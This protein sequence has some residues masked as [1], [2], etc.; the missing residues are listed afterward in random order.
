MASKSEEEISCPKCGH[1][2]SPRVDQPKRCPR[3]GKWLVSSEKKEDQKESEGSEIKRVEKRDGRVVEFDQSKITEAIWSAAQSIGGR[4]KRLAERLSDKVVKYI[5]ENIDK[6]VPHVEEIQDA[7]E[8]VLIEEGHAKTGKAYILYRKQ[9]EDMRKI[10]TTFLEVEELVDDYLAQRDWRVKENS[11]V[12]YSMSGLYKHAAESVVSNYTLDRIYSMEISDA[13]R[14]GDLHIHDLA[15]GIAGYCFDE[16]TRILTDD[17]LKYFN[18]LNGEDKVA[19]L[20]IESK[21]LVFQKPDKYQVYEYEG[22]L[23]H[24]STESMDLLVTPEHKLLHENNDGTISKV[25][26]SEVGKKSVIRPPKGVCNW[27]GENKKLDLEKVKTSAGVQSLTYP[28]FPL[29]NWQS[30]LDGIS[31]KGMS[32]RK[33]EDTE[34]LFHKL[35]KQI[36]KR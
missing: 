11:N 22:T 17:G 34:F 28:M 12:G 1:I 24:F 26:A 5:E 13:H 19:T 23:L 3:C 35:I 20:D 30:S 27:N 18:N 4:N 14:N 21:E 36:S 9:H 29:R 2:W 7:V 10:K 16:Q 32:T 15:F 31:Q 33:M 25:V 6:K 8:K